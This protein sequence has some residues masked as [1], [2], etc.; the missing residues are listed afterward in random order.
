MSKIIGKQKS[1]IL[2]QS[3]TQY[4][5]YQ[6]NGTG[7][8]LIGNRNLTSNGQQLTLVELS[9]QGIIAFSATP[10]NYYMNFSR[11]V[12]SVNN[13]SFIQED[14]LQSLKLSEMI[15]QFQLTFL[16]TNNKGISEFMLI[17]HSLED[18]IKQFKI[19]MNSTNYTMDKF[20]GNMIG[21]GFSSAMVDSVSFQMVYGGHCFNNEEANKN[22][23]IQLCD[24]TITAHDYILNYFVFQPEKREIANTSSESSIINACWQ[25]E[26]IVGTTGVG[27][28]AVIDWYY[29]Q[30]QRVAFV[31]AFEGW[32]GQLDRNLSY[33]GV[34]QLYNGIV[35]TSFVLPDQYSPEIEIKLKHKLKKKEIKLL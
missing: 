28:N 13:S 8:Q 12:I 19:S 30:G 7:I 2:V 11:V 20:V 6:F 10:I 1:Y 31:Q 3:Q 29:E 21:Q 17:Y 18:T 26:G 15:D 9:S 5:I 35:L 14:K 22:P 27:N 16:Q 4:A 33:C 34:S 25:Q 32:N 24:D 23:D